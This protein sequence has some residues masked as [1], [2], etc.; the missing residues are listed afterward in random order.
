MNARLLHSVLRTPGDV[1]RDCRDDHD[2]APLAA[3][4]LTTII[5]GSAL[6]GAA[7]GAWQ[8]G[9]Q[10]VYAAG[11]LPMVMLGT[12]IVS[13][14]V[15]Y[16]LSAVFGR[17]T[18]ARSILSLML[19]AGARC[20]LVLIAAAPVVWLITSFGASYELVKLAAALAYAMA[21][22]SA[23][24]VLTRG[25]ADGP[26]KKQ[27]LTLFVGIHLLIGAQAARCLRPYIGTPGESTVTLLTNKR[28]GGLVY[29]LYDGARILLGGARHEGQ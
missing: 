28:E 25:V 11:K 2:I 18:S 21:G 3:T 10:T 16:A 15:F 20:S 27:M 19:A 4:S 1:A 29:Q 13:A 26:G 6:F 23:L 8:G 5:A 24:G 12:L 22:L 9:L 14:P 7:V 17:A